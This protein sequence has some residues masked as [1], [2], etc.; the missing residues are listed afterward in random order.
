MSC[1]NREIKYHKFTVLILKF[2]IE[3]FTDPGLLKIQLTLAGLSLW[4]FHKCILHFS[5][6]A[7]CMVQFYLLP[8]PP[9]NPQDNSCPSGPGVGNC[10][11]RSCPRGRGVGQIYKKIFSLILRSTCYFSRGLHDGCGPQDYVLLRKNAEIAI[12]GEWLKRDNL[13][14]LKSVFQG[15]F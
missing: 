2:G 1:K 15:M 13:S 14:K 6:L 12:V 9:G 7:K 3:D 11:R 8:F 5:V 4:C 10:L